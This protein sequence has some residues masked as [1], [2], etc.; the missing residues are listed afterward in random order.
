MF[1]LL[2]CFLITSLIFIV[3]GKFFL[4]KLDSAQA[5]NYLIFDSFFVGFCITGTLLNIWSLFLPT[6]I[7]S[8]GFLI[9]TTLFLIYKNQK[10][11]KALLIN[12]Y[13]FAFKNKLLLILII[14]IILL[15]LLSAVIIPQNF[16]S[17]LYHINAIQWNEKYRVVPGLANFHDRF[18]FN[19]SVL[20]M[21][22]AFSFHV[23][24]NQYIFVISSICFLMFIVW[25]VKNIFLN[26]D[27]KGMMLIFFIYFFCFKYLNQ[28]S[29]PGTDLVPNILVSFLLLS[30]VIEVDV[31]KKKYLKFIIISIFC[32]TIKLS[33][34]P[35][36]LLG[37]FAVYINKELILKS[38]LKYTLAVL[39]L[40]SPWLIRNVI[41][42]G[43]LIY[44]LEQLDFFS[45]DWKIPAERV[46]ETKNWIYSWARIP[47][48]DLNQVLSY[49]FV[50]WFKIWWKAQLIE[51]N[52]LFIAA[53]FAPLSLLVYKLFFK[54][55]NVQH[56]V[57][58][59]L[60][61]YLGFIL[62]LFTA[63]DFRFSYAVVLFLAALTV[64][65]F[66]DVFAKWHKILEI[67]VYIGLLTVLVF[68]SQ[69]SHKLYIAEY[70]KDSQ[71]IESLYLPNDVYY[72]KLKRGIKFLD[73]KYET[74]NKNTITLYGPEIINSQ[75][76]DIFPC[77]PLLDM[78]FQLRGEAV[79]NGFKP[80]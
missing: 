43:Y 77:A 5:N 30:A 69:D 75:C 37:F 4:I 26:R 52:R 72:V 54:F 28:V 51:D 38:F 58:A 25:C 66:F 60:A 20:V 9:I 22:A 44:P 48:T 49:K 50:D 55:K 6:D 65:L 76:F 64:Y 57:I 16:D 8:L 53:I 68:I 47:F 33:V 59:V 3:I 67:L 11:F 10:V 2:F 79:E 73:K 45:F 46:I 18:G 42:T 21:G 63:P 32:L 23:L 24:Y 61:A 35:I 31:F 70:K 1:V 13:K 7:F 40:V 14:L 17:Y 15:V 62:W 41:L 80:N 78:R 34:L 39:L 71:I 29:S 74:A 12:A 56:I 19:S 36:I 27:A